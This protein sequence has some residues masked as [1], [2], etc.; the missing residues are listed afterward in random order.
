M[1]MTQLQYFLAVAE[2]GSISKAGERL[3]VSQPAISLQIKKLE[4][5][6]GFSLLYRTARGILLTQEGEKFYEG[7]KRVQ[8]AWDGLEAISAGLAHSRKERMTLHLGPRVFSNGLFPKLAAFFE[9]HAEIEPTFIVSNVGSFLDKLKTGEVDIALNY[10][11]GYSE[12]LSDAQSYYCCE[13]IREPQCILTGKD[14]VLAGRESVMVEELRGQT[15]IAAPQ[16]SMEAEVLNRILKKH[17]TVPSRIYRLDG[18]ET[19]MDMVRRGMG[20]VFGPQSFADYYD[21]RAVPLFPPVEESLSF[22]CLR[23]NQGRT[24]LKILLQYLLDCC[25]VRQNASQQKEML[26][27]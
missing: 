4:Q 11:S 21:V 13:L 18:I 12:I 10:V 5:E 26:S 17:D 19:S 20:V 24:A 23:E 15:L 22:V 6:L 2:N 3:F 16:E 8:E 27:S 9:R 25:G 7:A 14:T 1:N